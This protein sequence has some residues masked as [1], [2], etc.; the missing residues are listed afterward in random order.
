MTESQRESRIPNPESRIANPESGTA[1]PESGTAKPESRTANP[2]SRTANPESRIPDP[3]GSRMPD[4]A[5]RL[6]SLLDRRILILDGAMG[7][8]IQRYKLTEADFRGER[9]AKHS[10]DLKGDSDVLVLTRPDVISAIHHEYLA[11]GADIIETNTFGGTVIAQG[12]YGLEGAVY[13]INVEGARLAR[14]AADEWSARTPDRPRF[15][16]GSMGP[17]NRTLSISPDVNNPAF[18]ATTFDEM[19]AAYE[20]QTRGLIEGGSDLLLLETIFDTLVAKAALVAIENVFDQLGVRLPLIISVTITDRSGRTLSGQTID[21]F[22][23]SIRHAKPFSVGIN[24]ALGARDMRA[25]LAELAR[26]AECYVTSYPNAGLPNAFGEYDER[27]EETAALLRDFASSG[28]VNILGGCCGTTPDHIKAIAAAINGVAPR[29]RPAD[30]WLDASREQPP[31][32]QPYSQFSG[33]EVLTIRPDSNFQMIGERTNVTGSARFARLIK[34]GN[35]AEAVGVAADQVRGGA[36]LIDV[37]MD[38]GMLD[39]EQAMTT[40]L[41]YIATEPEIARVPVVVDSS[42][43]S[44]LEAGLKCIQ[45]KGVVNSISLKEGEED[46]LQKARTIHRYGAGVVVMAFDETGQADTVQRKVAICQR[47]YKLLTEHAGF[48]PTDI[49]F[50]PN[51]LAIA[52]GLEEHNDYAINYI[53]ATKIIKA[54]CPGVKV[55]GGVSNLSF[56]FRGNDVVRE[57]IHSAFLYHAIKAGMDMGIV[58][59]GQLVVYEDI[60]KDLLEHVE[61]IIFNRRPDATERLVQF[62]ES[63]KGSGKKRDA[64]LAWREGTVAARLSHALVHGIVDFIEADVEEARQQYADPLHIIEGPLMD[65]M[66]VVGDL[67][68]AGKMFLP[69]VVKSARAMKKAVAYLLPYMEEQKRLTGGSSSQGRVLMATVKGDV[70]DI[71]KNIVA[72]VLGCNNYEVIDLGVMVPAAKILDAA[73]EHKADVIGLSGLITPSLDEMAFVAREMDRRQ[74][75]LPL[76]IGGATTSRQHTAVKIA[77]EYNRSV[78]HVLDASRAVDVVSSLLG[79]GRSAFD[80]ANRVSQAEIRESYAA[81]RQKP[82][83]TYDQAFANRLQTDWDEHVIAS[84]WFVGRRYLDDVPLADIAKFIDWTFFFSAWELKGRFPAILDHAEYGPPAR[85]LYDNAQSLLRRIIDEKLLRANGV[86]AFWPANTVGDDIVVYTDDSR[87]EE[88]GRFPMLRQQEEIADRRPN[89]SLADFIAPRESGVPDYL[90]MFAV[91][92]GL[93]AD[94]LVRGFEQD[95]DDYN[96]IMVKALADRLAEAFAEYLHAQARRDWGYGEQ[97]SLSSE[98]LIAEKYRGI[99]PAYGYPACPDHSEKFKLFQLLDAG[100][101]GISLTDS[102]AMLPAA[103]VSGL[104]FSHPKAKYFNVGRIGRDQL[105]SYAKRKGVSIEEAER[106]LSPYLAYDPVTTGAPA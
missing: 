80:A 76:L 5:R 71:G 77:P 84:P 105:E 103:S 70:H 54:T 40:F 18:R 93:G 43:W 100:R 48:D 79:D 36:N 82:L 51:I 38:E 68:G 32:T 14:A 87:R 29:P 44:V 102:G 19:R 6:R 28:F 56:S 50:D 89:R 27:P 96:A 17:T 34:S 4:P 106:W 23:T 94:E 69:Q 20:T 11:A 83:L 63:V 30:S 45:G 10:R 35:Y 64:D 1:K 58:N 31:T 15:V 90:G 81:R 46:F 78:V 104:Y 25:Y 98:D 67:F 3:A 53:E 16:A 47:A 21:A 57:A 95:H 65:G 9:F 75:T 42:K 66:K 73:I 24:C 41:N 13:D 55:S 85:E 92:A 12:D 99:R 22:Y 60:P 101:Q 91:T 72:V 26:L 7:T 52:T 59:A 97:E 88:L 86:Y 74:F 2:E 62:A 61:D 33:L 37:N 49:I 8:M 39:S